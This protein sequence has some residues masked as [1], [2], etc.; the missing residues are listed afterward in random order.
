MQ[1]SFTQTLWRRR[2]LGEIKIV[3][4]TEDEDGMHPGMLHITIQV[5]RP[6]MGLCDQKTLSMPPEAVGQRHSARRKAPLSSWL[7]KP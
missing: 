3:E 4:K 1:S 6:P 2:Q 7:V 5:Q